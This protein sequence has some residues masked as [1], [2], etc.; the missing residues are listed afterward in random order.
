MEEELIFLGWIHPNVACQVFPWSHS[1]GCQK[2]KIG[3]SA[4]EVTFEW[5]NSSGFAHLRCKKMALHGSVLQIQIIEGIFYIISSH[6]FL[7]I[8]FLFKLN[9][10]EKFILGRYKSVG[11]CVFI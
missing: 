11:L 4:Q 8:W 6:F 1:R 9:V 5:K 7:K 3:S 2:L 10:L